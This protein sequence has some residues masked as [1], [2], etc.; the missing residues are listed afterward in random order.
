MATLAQRLTAVLQAIGGDMKSVLPW[1]AKTPPVG[2]VVGTTDAQTLANK[3]L[4]NPKINNAVSFQALILETVTTSTATIDFQLGQKF[5]VQV[6]ANTS[7]SFVFPGIGNYQMILAMGVA[8]G[9]A[10]T[11]GGVTWWV[12]ATSQPPLNT[13][14]SGRSLVSFYWDGLQLYCAVA[15]INAV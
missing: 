13:A 14:P 2:A 8:G 11:I 1:A 6:Q 12:G 7:L 9:F 3:T 5:F 15:K 4:E 10:V